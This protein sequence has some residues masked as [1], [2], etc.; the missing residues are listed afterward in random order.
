MEETRVRISAMM[1]GKFDPDK[2]DLAF[3][4]IGICTEPP[5]IQFRD[6]SDTSQY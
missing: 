5:K 2:P 4:I 1:K 6:K 3:T